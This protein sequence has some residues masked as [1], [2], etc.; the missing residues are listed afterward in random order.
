MEEE[1]PHEEGAEKVDSGRD[2][3]IDNHGAPP[4][5][6]LRGFGATDAPILLAGG[7]GGTYRSGGIVLKPTDD[8][9]AW[10]SELQSTIVDSRFRMP[11]PVKSTNGNWIYKAW[12]AWEYIEARHEPGRWQEQIQTCVYFH[13][14]ISTIPKPKAL[15]LLHLSKSVGPWGIADQVAWGEREITHHPRIEPSVD[16]LKQILRSVDGKN[17]LIHGDFQMMFSDN[18]PPTV[19]D[20]S[21]YWR[22][23]AFAVGIVVA[24]AL[25]WGNA[26]VSIIDYAQHIA[27]FNQFLARAELRRVVELETLQDMYGWD[28]LNEIDAHIPTI[29]HICQLC[30]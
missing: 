28:M 23:A 7:Q 27:N 1:L 5:D 17:Q 30:R 10:I 16:R 20:F 8:D 26:H 13:D 25:V 6:V 12:A 3:A 24:D 21:P 19:I 29:D 14:A 9:E 22:P 18:A 2:K 11:Q 15:E 4:A